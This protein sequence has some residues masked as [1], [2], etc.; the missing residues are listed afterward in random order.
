ML[1]LFS[2]AYLYILLHGAYPLTDGCVTN[3]P[4]AYFAHKYD[5][6]VGLGSE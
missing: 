1:C 5:I 6:W 2:Q 3:R 4:K